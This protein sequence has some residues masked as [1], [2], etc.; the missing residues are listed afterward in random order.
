VRLALGVVAGL[1]LAVTAGCGV[2]GTADGHDQPTE[3]AAP[4]VAAS[5]H[6]STSPAASTRNLRGELAFVAYGKLYLL[7]GPAGALRHVALPGIAVGPAWSPDDRWLAVEVCSPPPAGQPYLPTPATLWLVNAGGTSAKPVTPKSWQVSGFA[8]A[9]RGDELAVAAYLPQAPQAQSSV[10][11]TAAPTGKPRILV[12]GGDV[13]GPAWSPDGTGIAVGIGAFTGG[14]WHNAL[15]VLSVTGGP[16]T[17]VTATAGNVLDLAGW[18]PDGAGLLYWFD[19]QGS[20]SIAADGLPLDSVASASSPRTLVPTMLVHDSWLAFSPLGNA[21]AAVSGGDRVIWSGGKQITLCAPA[22]M[23]TPVRQPAGVV[24]VDPSWS[25]GGTQIVFARLSA[26][27]PFGPNGRADFSAYWITRW[28]AT[29][30]LWIAGADGSGARPLAAAGLGAVDPAWGRDGSVLFVRDD[31]LWLLPAG[32]PAAERL[33]GPLGALSGPA[34]YRTYYGYVP[35]PELFAWT[36]SQ[37][38]P[39]VMAQA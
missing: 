35:Y 2:T 10:V 9:P 26:S 30:R 1:V 14:S 27:G 19:Y 28:E 22:G 20:G 23:C 4:A 24:S 21:V 29:S 37:Q 3:A 18:W 7:G 33:T 25:P 39:A 15:D 31:S 13:T 12:S 36:L 11:A 16:Q 34:Y 5:V 17:T 32:A 6:W 8:W 38:Q